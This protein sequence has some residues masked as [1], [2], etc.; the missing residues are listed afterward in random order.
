MIEFPRRYVVVD[1]ETTGFSRHDRIVEIAA[2]TLNTLTWEIEDEFDTLINPER[3]VGPVGVHGISAS[4][5]EAAPTFGEIVAALARRL[6]QGILIGHNLQFDSRMLGLEFGRLG[7][8][9]KPWRRILY[10]TSHKVQ[11]EGGLRPIQHQVGASTSGRSLMPAQPLPW[12][13]AWRKTNRGLC[14]RPPLAMWTVSPIPAP[15]VVNS[16]TQV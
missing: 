1:V 15:F 4:M 8:A 7:V 13:N 3:D 11:A 16:P 12:P 5:V 2:V 14:N 9:F 6:H 10:A